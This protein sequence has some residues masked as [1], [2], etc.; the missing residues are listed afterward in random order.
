MF[1]LFSHKDELN[2]R[3]E[4]KK[5]LHVVFVKFSGLAVSDLDTQSQIGTQ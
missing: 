1:K 4:K 5:F 3:S 2:L